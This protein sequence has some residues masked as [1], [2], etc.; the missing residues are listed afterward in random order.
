MWANFGFFFLNNQMAMTITGTDNNVNVCTELLQCFITYFNIGVR[1]SGGI[2][3]SLNAYPYSNL[4]IYFSRYFHDFV[5]F[6]VIN[7]LL[8]N[9]INVIII[10]PFGEQRDIKEEIDEDIANN[11]FIC[12]LDRQFLQQKEIG[13]EEHSKEYHNVTT[14]LEYMLYLSKKKEKD[15]DADEIYIKDKIKNKEIDC[16]PILSCL[17]KN[18]ELIQK[19]ESDE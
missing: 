12:S 17:D 18:G 9:M 10:T 13:F 6:V 15:L 4:S 19:D 8:L 1:G 2:G 5:F 3:D 11:C 14:Y 7:L 16:F